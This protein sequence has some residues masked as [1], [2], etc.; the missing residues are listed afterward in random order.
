MRNDFYLQNL[1]IQLIV[2]VFDI[3]DEE[4]FRLFQSKSSLEF[5]CQN[6]T[7]YSISF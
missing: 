2:Y 3:Y 6:P 4:S 7:N 1:M 5:F